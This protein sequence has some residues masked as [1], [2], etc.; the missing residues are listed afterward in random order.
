[1]V[2]R[3][4]ADRKIR[5]TTRI[6]RDGAGGHRPDRAVMVYAQRCREAYP[7]V[8]L[9]I[10]SIEASLRRIA[11]YDYWSDKVRRS[12]L[13]DSKAAILLST[14]TPSG[15]WSTRR[16]GW[17]RASRS[18]AIRDLRGTAFWCRAP[19]PA[20]DGPSSTRHGRR[21]GK[22]APPPDPYRREAAKRKRARRADQQLELAASQ[23]RKLPC[24]LYARRQARRNAQRSVIRP[25]R[26]RA[27]QPPTPF[28]T[29]TPRA[30]LPSR[31][32]PR[33]RP[34]AGSAPR[35]SATSG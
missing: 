27:G 1:M 12:V 22:L 17:P 10:G 31:I 26:L 7:D 34:G 28:S 13:P 29:R 30:Y 20:E 4:T 5:R 33:Q 9:V 15:R 35:R 21:P 6:H 18:Q 19:G 16:T 2:N 24:V 25:A 8:P 32:E 14:A 3:Y 11:H 23:C